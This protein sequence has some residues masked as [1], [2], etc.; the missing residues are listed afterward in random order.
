MAIEVP[1]FSCIYIP[2]LRTSTLRGPDYKLTF[3]MAFGHNL[4]TGN[5]GIPPN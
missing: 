3:P 4:V 2:N 5:L 1:E